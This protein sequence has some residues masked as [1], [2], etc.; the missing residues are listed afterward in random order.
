MDYLNSPVEKM[1][2]KPHKQ[3]RSKCN[4]GRCDKGACLQ[5]RPTGRDLGM[6]KT[7]YH[8]SRLLRA[9]GCSPC[10]GSRPG[11]A[12]Y[13]CSWGWRNRDQEVDSSISTAKRRGSVLAEDLW[14]F[15][16]GSKARAGEVGRPLPCTF[17]PGDGYIA[18]CN[19]TGT[20]RQISKRQGR[21]C[22][23]GNRNRQTVRRRSC[24]RPVV[25]HAGV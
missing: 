5:Q 18:F 4:Q 7:T 11:L 15:T 13:L 3:P 14:I 21:R 23:G 19:K 17:A 25:L 10:R 16:P 9:I 2:T 12:L 20:R 24:G 6:R 8:R 1:S 22:R